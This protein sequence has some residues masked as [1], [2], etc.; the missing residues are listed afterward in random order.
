MGKITRFLWKSIKSGTGDSLSFLDQ[1]FQKDER[2][3]AKFGKEKDIAHKRYQGFSLTGNTFL[4]QETSREHLLIFG[5]SGVG[6]STVY[7]IPS[8]INAGLH[9]SSLVINN[10]S[11][12]L[13]V[14]ENFYR[15]RGY[16][17]LIFDPNDIEKTI[18]YNPMDFIFSSSDSAKIAQMLVL[19]G[20]TSSNDFW[21]LKST[22]L[23]VFVMEVLKQH[24]DRQ[25]HNLANVYAFLEKLAGEED[26]VSSFLSEVCTP[27]Q[28]QKYMA[29]I[30]NSPNAKSGIISSA[31]ASL[32]F[33]GNDENLCKL[34]SSSSFD[35]TSMRNEKTVLFLNCN[36]TQLSY[37]APLLGLFFEQVFGRLFQQ[38]PSSRDIPVFFLIDELS[39]I[40]IPSL[41][42][43]FSNARKYFGIL[44]L[45]QSENQLYENYGQYNAK[46]IINNANKVYMTGL[47]D[48]CERLEK[49]LGDYQYYDKD[50]VLRTRPLIPASGIRTMPKNHVLV[51]P[52]AGLN[53]LLCKVTSYYKIKAFVNYLQE[54]PARRHRDIPINHEVHYLPWN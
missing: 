27:K 42:M 38:I 39:S 14:L 47:T 37:Y 32:S 11:G 3:K 7:Q 1:F 5:P 50:K 29:L 35:I 21:E 54:R 4:S 9:G 16:K 13:S 10:P 33:I 48:E 19:K 12:E 28:W 36:T 24:T 51:L 30:A 40:P 31:L 25:Y 26:V 41:A 23:L 49:A 8:C 17:V 20:K 15:N 43:V 52:T 53:P 2:I 46:T 45:L 34:T 18:G 22:E 6:K 44:G